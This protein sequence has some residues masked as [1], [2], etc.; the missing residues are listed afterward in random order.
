MEIG[1]LGLVS[2]GYL[3]FFAGV[4]FALRMKRLDEGKR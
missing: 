3:C 2:Y 1:L 4:A